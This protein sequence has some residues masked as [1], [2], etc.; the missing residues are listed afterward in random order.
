MATGKENATALK[1]L[2]I[3][4][5]APRNKAETNRALKAYRTLKNKT[6]PIKSQ[7]LTGHISTSPHPTQRRP[8][9][10]APAEQAAPVVIDDD[11]DD[12]KDVEPKEAEPV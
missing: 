7:V 5:L 6:Y 8:R 4:H 9:A 2:L 1:D 12:I 10:P 3:V 11:V